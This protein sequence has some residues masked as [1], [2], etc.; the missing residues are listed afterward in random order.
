[1]VFNHTGVAVRNMKNAIQKIKSIMP[2]KQV[3]EIVHD[4]NQNAD[5]CMITLEDG[6]RIELVSGPVVEGYIKKVGNTPYHHC[7]EVK[8]IDN[9]I[10][11]MTVGGSK[12]VSA[13]KEAVLFDNRKVAFLSTSIGLIELVEQEA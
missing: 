12:L 8:N 1:M 4:L 11:K 9:A 3:G 7:Y 13:P 2:I 5:L 10:E 6:S